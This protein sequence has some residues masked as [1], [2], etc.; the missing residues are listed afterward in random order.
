MKAWLHH[1]LTAALV[2]VWGIN[3]LWCKVLGQVPRHQQIVASILGEGVAP[4]LVV[5]IGIAE[6]IM[7][8][9]ILSGRWPWLCTLAQVVVI[10]AMNIIE[11]VLAPELLLF[12]RFNLLLAVLLCVVVVVR[13]RNQT[14]LSR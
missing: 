2:A 10:M 7:V 6:L 9:W 1:V 14:G 12:G 13:H 8:A 4:V 3:G 11:Q 5:L